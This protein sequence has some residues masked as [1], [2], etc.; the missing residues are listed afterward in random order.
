M[1]STFIVRL[2]T[3]VLYRIAEC[4]VFDEQKSSLCPK[5]TKHLK[6]FLACPQRNNERY[7]H[8]IPVIVRSLHLTNITILL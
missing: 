6:M 4:P 5:C 3:R 2:I 7:D 1:K 8:R